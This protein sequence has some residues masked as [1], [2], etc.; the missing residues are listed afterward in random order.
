MK[1]LFVLLFLI[2]SSTI[3]YSQ[4]IDE[5]T[6][7]RVKEFESED[8]QSEN[9]EPLYSSVKK[10]I[11]S[12]ENSEN[13]EICG[14]GEKT[15]LSEAVDEARKDAIQT[16]VQ[17]SSTTINATVHQL[18]T[19]IN[20]EVDQKFTFD[21]V[22]TISANPSL[23]KHIFTVQRLSKKTNKYEVKAYFIYNE[24]ELRNDA[25]ERVKKKM[26]ES[27]KGTYVTANNDAGK[28]VLQEVENYLQDVESIVLVKPGNDLAVYH[29]EFNFT[30]YP[31]N[32]N[33]LLYFHK[34][35]A[36]VI[37]TKKNSG[38]YRTTKT[39]EI[40]DV[41]QANAKD[42][43]NEAYEK[44]FEKLKSENILYEII[45]SIKTLN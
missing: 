30:D 1:L 12:L 27:I 7:K 3:I 17:L 4:T 18:T 33:N 32:Y 23:F 36:S 11:V 24:V 9:N 21:F 15:E 10:I 28:I 25:N 43:K 16:F 45:N 42:A 20:G 29:V 39:I 38:N 35:K 26:Q 19:L 6:E 34:L 2:L 14:Y 44:V 22:N 5:R 41:Q 40:E 31:S 37:V 13:K 8:W